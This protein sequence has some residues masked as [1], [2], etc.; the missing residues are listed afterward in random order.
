MKSQALK[1]L[2]TLEALLYLNS[3]LHQ[4]NKYHFSYGFVISWNWPKWN[5][6]LYH[7]LVYNCFCQSRKKRKTPFEYIAASKQTK[8]DE[9]EEIKLW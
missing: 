3:L 5:S 7:D 9:M 8:S 2:L 1:S 6:A 4:P